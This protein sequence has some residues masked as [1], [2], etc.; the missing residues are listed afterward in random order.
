MIDVLKP[1]MVAMALFRSVLYTVLGVLRKITFCEML[2]CFN[3]VRRYYVQRLADVAHEMVHVVLVVIPLLD[4][5]THG[6]NP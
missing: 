4:L 2:R 6:M 3:I 5:N 1:S